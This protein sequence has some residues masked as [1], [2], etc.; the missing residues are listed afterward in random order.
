MTRTVPTLIAVEELSSHPVLLAWTRLGHD[1]PDRVEQMR[2]PTRSKPA[3]YRLEFA[4]AARLR[5]FAKHLRPEDPPAERRMLESVLPNLPVTTPNCLGVCDEPDGH[6]WLFVE[7]VG[8]TCYAPNDPEQR[9]LVARWLGRM[10]GAAAALATRVPLPDA[11]PGRYLAKLR[12]AR[13]EILLRQGNRALQ[14]DDHAV[15]RNVLAR[16]DELEALW[17]AIER[18]CA[19]LPTTLV[20]A[21]FQPKNLRLR[22]SSGG[23]ALYPIDWETAGWGVPAADLAMASSRKLSVSVDPDEYE[24]AVR[25]LLPELDATTIQRLSSIG[26]IFQT[27]AGI[28][29]AT[30]DLRFE[31]ERCLIRPISSMRVYLVR[32][33]TALQATSG[34]LR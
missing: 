31:W 20:H 21:D 17:P 25:E 34:W 10:H 4:S 11:G 9:R 2:K 24:R 28:D 26:H 22:A 13:A 8:E 23:L 6:A 27:M 18:Y 33:E 16:L 5:V 3:L 30:A 12:S 15:L 29:W 19:S 32:I 7:D 1:V 14:A